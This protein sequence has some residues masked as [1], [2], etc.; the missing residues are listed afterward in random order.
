MLVSLND[1]SFTM[2]PQMFYFHLLLN[3]MQLANLT[4]TG[5]SVRLQKRYQD[6]P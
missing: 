5:T 4:A 3:T 1:L 2:S 6:F